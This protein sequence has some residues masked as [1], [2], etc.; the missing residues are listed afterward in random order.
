MAIAIHLAEKGVLKKIQLSEAR[1]REVIESINEGMFVVRPDWQIELWNQALERGSGRQREQILNRH[2]L[3]A[4]PGLAATPLVQAI[5]DAMQT[6]NPAIVPDFRPSDLVGNR[7]FEARVFPF[8]AGVTVFL[9][10]ITQRKEAEETMR[11][12]REAAEAAS[13]AKSHF[14]ANMS[15]EIRTPMNGVIGLTNLVLDTELTAEQNE[16]LQMVMFSAT[17]LLAIIN[18]ILDFSKIEA[19]K[20]EFQQEVFALQAD[21]PRALKP[22]TSAAHEKGLKLTCEIAPPVPSQLIGDPDRLHQV[23][24]NLLGNALKFTEQ[25]EI[26]VRVSV[27]SKTLTDVCLC[28]SVA[29]TGIGIPAEK[30]ETIFAAFAQADGSTTRKYG[31]TGLGLTISARLV[32]LMGG[33]ICVESPANWNRQH[34]AHASPSASPTQSLPAGGPGSSF[35][36]LARFGL[37][38]LPTD[39]AQNSP[40]NEAAPGL[41]LSSETPEKTSHESGAVGSPPYR[42]LVAEDNPV[43]QRLM[44]KLLAK[45]GHSVR[46]AEHG[47]AAL[48]ALAQESFDL[49][50]MDVQ[51]PEMGGLEATSIIRQQETSTGGHLPIIALTARAMTGDREECLQAGMDDYLAKPI[52]PEALAEALARVMNR[53]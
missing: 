7:L 12:A 51:M 17:S 43:N 24:N 22:L 33:H 1:L 4:L 37:P 50:L 31:G 25:G 53:A 20:L 40:S 36:F 32:E 14:L 42:I 11:Q 34:G 30:Q 2:L 6:H 19:G 45:Q 13:Q 29:D 27:E 18:D 8:A 23:L 38:L 49:V 28:F 10:D 26:R 39:A 9:N 47:R 41:P 52:N 5:Q 44:A 15:H 48:E 3:E 46:L 35:H 21:L 16:L